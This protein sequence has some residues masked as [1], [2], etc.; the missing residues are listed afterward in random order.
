MESFDL[1]PWAQF[2][3]TALGGGVLGTLATAYFTYRGNIKNSQTD[4]LA[5]FRK[6]LLTELKDTKV[7]YGQLE[8][9]LYEARKA[10]L[11]LEARY[12][13]ETGQLKQQ[14]E[15]LRTDLTTLRKKHILLLQRIKKHPT[16]YADL[17]D[18][19]FMDIDMADEDIAD[20]SFPGM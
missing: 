11:D 19:F 20:S 1:N 2:I 3:L 9:D 6:E 15:N 18:E 5:A 14:N 17:K 12:A 4:D 8:K 13:H 16:L 10:A 7:R